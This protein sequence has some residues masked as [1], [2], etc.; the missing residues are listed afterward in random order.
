MI[1]NQ[2]MILQE[3]INEKERIKVDED[4]LKIYWTN[5]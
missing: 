2:T 5:N 4:T 1:Q 3:Y